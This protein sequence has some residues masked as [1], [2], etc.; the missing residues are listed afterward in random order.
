MT[1]SS[2]FYIFSFPVFASTSP[3]ASFPY[4]EPRIVELLIL[5]S[6]IFLLNVSRSIADYFL[7]G[8]II[9]EIALGMVYGRPL[10]AILPASWEETFTV[11]GYLGLIGIVFAGGLSTELPLLLANLPLSTLCALTGIGL[12]VAFS[13]ALLT[14]GYGYEPLEAF[15]AGA[16]LSSTSLGTTLMALNSVASGVQDSGAAGIAKREAAKLEAEPRQYSPPLHKSR[17]G[18]IL[19]SAAVIDDV[20]GLVLA[21]LVPA[22][23][24]Q[25]GA[26]EPKTN[27]AW[28]IIR[29]ILSSV[30]M[31]VITPILARFILRPIYWYRNFGPR[32]CLPREPDKPWGCPRLLRMVS[33]RQVD[34]ASEDQWGT[35]CHAD[36]IAISSMI[37]GISAFSAIAFYSGSSV[38]F[39]AYLAGLTVAYIS[40]PQP[41]GTLSPAAQH[42]VISDPHTFE[43]TYE[44]TVG[45]LQRTLLAPLFFAS[46]GYAIPFLSLWQPRILWRGILY[47]ILMGIAKLCVGVPI[48]LCGTLTKPPQVPSSSLTTRARNSTYP[49]LF[50]GV[51]MIAR[52]EIGLLIAQLART[53]S[54]SSSDRGL[55]GDEVFL[56]CI[57]AILLCTLLSPIS[58]GIIVRRLGHK[59]TQGI[60][61][62]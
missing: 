19:I 12:P 49:A 29:P 61:G 42:T 56:V 59:I 51:A 4:P 40:K 48:L 39:G 21:S 2:L 33:R 15:A 13:F 17:I 9:A 20:I 47:A 41:T 18:T 10:A 3:G 5:V 50:M 38:L 24:L 11:L 31:A 27:L 54:S 22:L 8:G 53:Q 23:S 28:T 6:F 1:D 44:R 37:L 55:L 7:H 36:V 26:S 62:R 32:W 46:I 35:Q 30:L 45:P 16:A 60:W 14:A 25:H 34:S 52:G 58:L 43:A 57:W